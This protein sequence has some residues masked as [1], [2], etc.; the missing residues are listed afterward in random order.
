MTCAYICFACSLGSRA[1]V[2]LH[3]IKW[4][5]KLFVLRT[6]FRKQKST[7]NQNHVNFSLTE[8]HKILL[9]KFG[10]PKTKARVMV[11]LSDSCLHYNLCFERRLGISLSSTMDDDA[12]PNRSQ[13]KN[14]II[15]DRATA[16][17]CTLCFPFRY[18]DLHAI[19]SISDRCLT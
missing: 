9:A 12:M 17:A 10:R 18:I 11:R 5:I 4:R 8:R 13:F 16:T 19:E 7:I 3:V 1:R 14:S 15:I 6:K 2:K